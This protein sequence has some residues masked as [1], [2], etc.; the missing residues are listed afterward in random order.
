MCD[1]K[2][3]VEDYNNLNI[4]THDVRRLHNLNS[5]EYMEIRKMAVENGDIPQT[6]HMNQRNAKFY[7]RRSDGTFDVQKQFNGKKIYVGRFESEEIAKMIVSKCIE[8]NWEIKGDLKILI[9]EC[10]CKPKNYSIVNGY[11]V[12]Q[13]SLNGRNEVYATLDTS[14]FEEGEIVKLV[15]KFRKVEWNKFSVANILKEVC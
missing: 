9:E 12:I 1:Y 4:T 15:E 6:R 7:T 13:K 8:N 14:K 5:R 3:F 2:A 11:Y 10:K